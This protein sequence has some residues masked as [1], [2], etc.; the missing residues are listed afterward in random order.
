MPYI[1]FENNY[2]LCNWLETPLLIYIRLAHTDDSANFVGTLTQALINVV[3]TKA[4]DSV[5]FVVGTSINNR[6]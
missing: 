1:H 6:F 2:L 4:F 5:S 3:S